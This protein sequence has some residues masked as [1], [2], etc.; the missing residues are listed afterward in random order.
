LTFIVLGPRA[1]ISFCILLDARVPI[2]TTRLQCV[3]V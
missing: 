1:M 3:G 2:G